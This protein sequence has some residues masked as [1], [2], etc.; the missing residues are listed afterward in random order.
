MFT[1][2]FEG[3]ERAAQVFYT[4]AAELPY[5]MTIVNALTAS[6]IAQAARAM[7]PE[8]T[9]ELRRSITPDAD[10]TGF[11]VGTDLFYAPYIEYGTRPHMP[12]P[13]ALIPW[14]LRHGMSASAA[15]A[16]ALK[17]A[18]RG[19]PAQPYLF[20]AYEQQRP[21]YLAAVRAALV[22]MSR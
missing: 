22:E 2:E 21:Q 12:P 13:A 8:D 10:E 15:Y 19:T 4:W 6:A 1:F 3:H 7:A 18:Q 14:V 17:I 11:M 16:I 20:P 5:R 9:G